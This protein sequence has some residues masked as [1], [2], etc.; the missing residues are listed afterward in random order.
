MF[1]TGT[2]AVPIPKF[3]YAL[4]IWEQNKYFDFKEYSEGIE[5]TAE[6]NEGWYL[7]DDAATKLASAM[8]WATS[9][10]NGASASYGVTYDRGSEKFTVSLASS[11]ATGEV[12]MDDCSAT[13][14]W[15][16]NVEATDITV[17]AGNSGLD[18]G[19]DGGLSVAATYFRV[20]DSVNLGASAL[21]DIYI[22][23]LAELRSSAGLAVRFGGTAASYFY[24]NYDTADLATGWNYNLGGASGDF[25]IQGGPDWEA[26]VGWQVGFITTNAADTIAHG[27]VKINNIRRVTPGATSLSLLLNT[28]TNTASGAATGYGFDTSADAT[29]ASAY[30]SDNILPNRIIS[31]QPIRRP[32]PTF[33][34][35]NRSGM[36][37]SGIM[38][39]RHIRTDIY[40]EFL[41][42]N[43][44]ENELKDEWAIFMG[45]VSGVPGPWP[46][47][48][49][50]EF[51]P[52]ATASGD[53]IV[54]HPDDTNWVPKEMLGQKLP[55]FYS[56]T[57]SMREVIPKAGTLSLVDI[58]TRS[59]G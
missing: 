14:N 39:S 59:P 56:W 25:S 32:V 58:Y 4:R 30:E 31:S 44:P 34:G 9:G 45:K 36:S 28:G 53:Y 11:G 16:N 1:G 19:K 48:Q 3:I 41:M 15:S 42:S 23:S 55:A 8:N 47:Q 54:F 5:I 7:P 17:A 43:I 35:M 10:A 13:A 2:E 18:C 37:E 38:D 40:F 46:G 57:M 52:K 29:G 22:T 21:M 49:D 27:N 50:F 12:V 33:E 6:I 20:I 24:I 26:C 51:Y